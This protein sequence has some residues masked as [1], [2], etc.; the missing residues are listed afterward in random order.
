LVLRPWQVNL[1]NTLLA[2]DDDGLLRHRTAI[3][4]TAKKNGKSQLGAALSLWALVFGPQGGE[5]ISVAG[6]REQAAICFEMAKQ[7]VA[8]D[9]ELST[10]IKPYRSALVVESTSSSYKVRS[11]DAPG[12]QGYNPSWVLFDE[13]EVQPNRELW[14]AMDLGRAARRESMLLAVTTAGPRTDS[15]GNPTICN[16]I[17]EYAKRVSSGEQIDPTFFGAIW[18]A[19]ADAD[20]RSPDTWT[21]SNPGLGDLISLADFE[22]SIKKTP[23]AVFRTWRCNQFVASRLTWLP[24]G[25]WSA[26]EDAGRHLQPGEVPCVLAFDGSR[27]QDSTA[28]V[29]V[30]IEDE[31]HVKLLRLWEKGPEDDLHWRLSDGE[32]MPALRNLI[33]TWKPEQLVC[34]TA[35][36]HDQLETLSEEL[37]ADRSKTVVVQINQRGAEMIR[38]TSLFYEAVVQGHVSH[39]GS[40]SLSRHLD[41]AVVKTTEAGSRLSKQS[42]GSAL[43][44][45][46]AVAALMGFQAA[47]E[48]VLE[49]E[50]VG[51][52]DLNELAAQMTPEKKHQILSDYQSRM[53]ALIEAERNRVMAR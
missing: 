33:D 22:S 6:D 34:D 19:L 16:E 30:T 36:W 26:L 9:P 8:M 18:T 1:L 11:S 45:D 44:I 32:V 49:E 20:W 12:A 14:D 17:W 29:L 27:S 13:L 28:I 7:M 23:E 47:K 51:F 46:A 37:E 5:V 10:I 48:I 50:G 25:S 3:A 41:N 2:V 35:Y 15:L 4:S 53:S 43:R 42:R 31:P 52:A 40:P 21:Q 24:G 38:A 39:D